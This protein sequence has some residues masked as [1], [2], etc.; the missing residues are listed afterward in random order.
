MIIRI[1]VAC[2]NQD[3]SAGNKQPSQCH[4]ATGYRFLN[5]LS[6]Q[7]SS[8][9]RPWN[10]SPDHDHESPFDYVVYLHASLGHLAFTRWFKNSSRSRIHSNVLSRRSLSWSPDQGEELRNSWWQIVTQIPQQLICIEV[11]SRL[12]EYAWAIA[13]SASLSEHVHSLP[14]RLFLKSA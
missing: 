2:P 9:S 11:S 5:S 7:S 8:G 4:C 6:T 10:A 13:A 14:N 3:Q 12:P 1:P